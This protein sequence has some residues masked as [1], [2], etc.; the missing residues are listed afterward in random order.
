MPI[1]IFD[2][3]CNLCNGLVDFIMK[4]NKT[5]TFCAGQSQKGKALLKQYQIKDF[6]SIV[7]IEDG[8]AYRKSTAIL[9]TFRKLGA[10]WPLLYIF[11]IVPS[12][13]RNIIYDYVANHRYKWFG[14]QKLC[15]IPKKEEQKRFC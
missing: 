10:L 5:I 7:L 8:K 11:F 4:R 12:F 2:G 13:I 14:K 6:K 9:L 15:R 3:I 1:L